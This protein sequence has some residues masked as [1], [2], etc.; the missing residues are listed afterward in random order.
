MEENDLDMFEDTPTINDIFY[1][2]GE[3]VTGPFH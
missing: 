3:F 2:N 1:I